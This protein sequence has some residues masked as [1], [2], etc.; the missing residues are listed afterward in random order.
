MSLFNLD[1]F[2]F[3]KKTKTEEE[4]APSPSLPTSEEVDATSASLDDVNEDI[5]LP[6]ALEDNDVT[7]GREDDDVTDHSSRP[8]T[9][10]SDVSEKTETVLLPH[11]AQYG[12]LQNLLYLLRPGIAVLQARTW[13]GH[14]AAGSS[15]E[16]TGVGHNQPPAVWGGEDDRNDSSVP[17]T[18]EAKRTTKL[19]HFKYRKDVIELSSDSEE[20]ASPKHS[21]AKELPAPKKDVIVISE[22][23]DTEQSDGEP[24]KC[25]ERN[26]PSQSSKA[27][28]EE[29]E[30]EDLNYC[31][32]QTLKE[33]FPQISDQELLQLIASND[34]MDGAI[35]AGLKL[36]EEGGSRKRKLE[37]SA[38]DD[39]VEIDDQSTKKKKLDPLE[40]PE[41]KWERR[42]NL[43]SKLH[44]EFPSLNKEELRDAL[45]EHNWIFREAL[46]SLKVYMEDQEVKEGE[47]GAQKYYRIEQN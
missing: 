12:Q 44:S 32:L 5:P 42:E 45:R 47:W 18:P 23:S 20:E 24:P 9:P 46:D 33:L 27:L 19:S 3:E 16:A 35:A 11:F 6:S 34:T 7:A 13:C 4:D 29:D 26:G 8:G 30:E 15:L 39:A 1:R 2:R 38:R 17:E 28:E 21:S 10:A 14:G 25:I 41:N 40:S 31:K 43:V 36:S 37:E 22:P